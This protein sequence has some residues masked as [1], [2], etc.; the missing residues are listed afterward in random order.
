MAKI[1]TL[2]AFIISV[3]LFAQDTLSVVGH[4]DY[5]TLLSDVTGYADQAGNE[6]AIVSTKTGVSIVDL[7]IPEEP[8]ELFFLEGLDNDYRDTKIWNGYAYSVNDAGGGLEIINLNSLPFEPT[9]IN[10][11][12]DDTL[13]LENAHNIVMSGD[14][15]MFLL[16]YNATGGALILDLNNSPTNPEIVGV[17]N[18]GYIDDAVYIDNKLWAAQIFDGVLT[19]IDCTDKSN[20]IPI[21]TQDTPCANT[22]GVGVQDS[23]WYMYTTD[24]VP[25]QC[26]TAYDL[27]H[28]P[29]EMEEMSTYRSPHS[30]N[31]IPNK[32]YTVGDY[33]VIA[34]YSDGVIILDATYPDNL[35][36]IGYY[37][38][39]PMEGTGLVGC[40]GIYPYLPSG[41]ILAAD[42]EEGLFVFC[43]YYREGCYLFAQV[44]DANSET[45]QFNVN[46]DIQGVNA[47]FNTQTSLFGE[48]NYGVA[49]SGPVDIIISKTGYCTA[50]YQ[51]VCMEEGEDLELE[52]LLV[53][54]DTGCDTLFTI[55]SE[56]SCIINVGDTACPPGVDVIDGLTKLEMNLYPNPV[57]N[58][59]S[60][61]FD[62]P[63]KKEIYYELVDH[64]GR[65]R[66][67]GILTKNLEVSDLESG[68]FVIHLFDENQILGTRKF[69]KID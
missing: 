35:V 14:G 6:Y 13:I 47:D 36:E 65:L 56:E 44:L 19:V 57:S 45:P 23:I 42:R 31:S 15:Y 21:F 62:I 3:P 38:T 27:T 26:I 52:I 48:F 61:D 67:K 50:V 51:N 63:N 9:S 68:L 16:G 32:V 10:W 66:K 53:P 49:Q 64:E 5:S 29:D 11:I 39:S 43:P 8:T 59:L 60:I 4:L 41:K 33:L 1:I 17:Y 12:G 54:S 69:I 40:W 18:D 25:D 55:Y 24:E 28:F 30:E 7:S 22:H 37:D 58:Q 46:I 2:L 34:H 20:P